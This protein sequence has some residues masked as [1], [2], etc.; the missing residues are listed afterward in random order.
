M[1]FLIQ[2]TI[3]QHLNKMGTYYIQD[4][5]AGF[6]RLNPVNLLHITENHLIITSFFHDELRKVFEIKDLELSCDF[7]IGTIHIDE[8]ISIKDYLLSLDVYTLKENC[9]Y[10]GEQ[11]VSG[12]FS[13]LIKFERLTNN[14]FLV[15]I[16]SKVLVVNYLDSEKFDLIDSENVET[17]EDFILESLDFGCTRKGKFLYPSG[18]I[19]IKINNSEQGD[20]FK[21]LFSLEDFCVE[22][23]LRNNKNV[24][25]PET[26]GYITITLKNHVINLTVIRI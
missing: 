7:Y 6:R 26:N 5:Q 3:P 25:I 17:F 8:S 4:I 19:N 22:S 15:T 23:N 21:T 2:E 9:L 24:L 13:P 10:K 20:F 14:A 18:D 11:K 16:N 1:N 12:I